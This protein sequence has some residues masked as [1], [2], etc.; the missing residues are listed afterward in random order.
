V[1]GELLLLF[2]IDLAEQNI[3]VFL[4]DLLEDRREAFTGRA[5]FGPEIEDRDLV[6]ADL[7]KFS[8]VMVLSG[9]GFLRIKLKTHYDIIKPKTTFGYNP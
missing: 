3:G 4:R 8:A 6:T 9:M 7:L 2:G 1:G 5:P